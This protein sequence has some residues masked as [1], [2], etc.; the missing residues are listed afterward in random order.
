MSNIRISP[1]SR[2][3]FSRKAAGSIEARD[4]QLSDV[5]NKFDNIM[6]RCTLKTI[7]E[8]EVSLKSFSQSQSMGDD[9]IEEEQEADIDDIVHHAKAINLNL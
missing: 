9:E 2:D 1:F 4:D 5:N 7:E 6:S 8:E 3:I